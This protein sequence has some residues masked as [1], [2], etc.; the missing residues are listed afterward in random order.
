MRRKASSGEG[1]R[2]EHIK[3]ALDT[4]GAVRAQLAE[5]RA[6]RCR[7]AMRGAI[8]VL[9]DAGMLDEAALGEELLADVELRQG[10]ETRALTRA[11]A[12]S[13]LGKRA[14]GTTEIR[15]L[16]TLARITARSGD[17]AK[18]LE[19]SHQALRL[20][21]ASENE[22]VMVPARLCLSATAWD[23]GQVHGAVE[24]AA[25]AAESIDPSAGPLGVQALV[26]FAASLLRAKSALAAEEL[27]SRCLRGDLADEDRARVLLVRGDARLALGVFGPA[28]RDFRAARRLGKTA[29]DKRIEP[30]ALG[31]LALALTL[32]DGKEEGAKG[33]LRRSLSLAR[34]LRNRQFQD[35]VEGLAA[36]IADDPQGTRPTPKQAIQA[37]VELARASE[38]AAVV[39]AC[40]REGV[41]LNSLPQGEPAFAVDPVLVHWRA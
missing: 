8:R 11:K 15:T 2:E 28:A 7:S 32:L 6:P 20:A 1:S 33:S 41:R 31:M 4:L 26:A 37:L 21:R 39:D 3:T 17:P 40:V 14:G 30:T 16:L 19:H 34:R 13:R 36:R 23:A 25:G 29:A 38:R 22:E 10:S 27:L 5:G 18:A 12:A 24:A 9:Q 35:V